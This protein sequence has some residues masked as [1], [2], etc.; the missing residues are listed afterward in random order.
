MNLLQRRAGDREATITNGE[1]HTNDM[2][3]CVSMDA[4]GHKILKI[5]H[6]FQGGRP[7]QF[8][9]FDEAE[10][11][12]DRDSYLR[13]EYMEVDVHDLWRAN[14]R[15]RWNLQLRKNGSLIA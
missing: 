13:G 1:Y 6:D 5:Y 3:L 10:I 11:A 14:D 4:R 15:F 9:V 7:I 12:E 8:Y 2:K